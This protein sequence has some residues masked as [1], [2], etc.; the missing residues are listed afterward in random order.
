MSCN[1][2]RYGV[3]CINKPASAPSQ[4]ATEPLPLL[5]QLGRGASAIG[6]FMLQYAVPVLAAV[7]VHGLLAHLR[8]RG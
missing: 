3:C 1:L 2:T 4:I 6:G 5:S 7:G 8:R